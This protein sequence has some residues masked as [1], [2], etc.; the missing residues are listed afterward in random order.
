MEALNNSKPLVLL[1]HGFLSSERAWDPLLKLLREDDQIMREFDFACFNYTTEMVDLQPHHRIPRVKECA[2]ALREFMDAPGCYNR[3]IHLVGHSQ[4]GLIIQG[5]L[6]LMLEAGQGEALRPLRQVMMMA[7]PNLGSE[8][9]SPLR[10][11]V[12]AVFSNPQERALRVLDPDMADIRSVI[13]ERVLGAKTGGSNAWPVPIHIFYGSQDRIVVE[14]SARGQFADANV[15]PLEADHFTIITP[16]DRQDQRYTK[17][18]DALLDPSG[19]PSV[20]EI[21]LYETRVTV[22]PSDKPE[23]ECKHGQTTKMVATDNIGFIERAVTFSHRNRCSDSFCI[24]YSTR[25][26]GYVSSVTSHRNEATP[27]EKGLYDDGGIQTVFRFMPKAGEQYRIKTDVYGG[28]GQGERDV[29]FH[30]SSSG[31]SYSKRRPYILDLSG[32]LSKV[33]KITQ[34]PRLYFHDNDPADHDMC[35][36]RGL[37]DLVKP[38]RVDDSGV[39]TWEFTR[40]SRG[41]VDITWDF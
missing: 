20:Y 9:L 18:S 35:S 11:I 37:G 36:V 17:F 8:F 38:L 1:V 2:K 32:Y 34:G 23:Y 26:G 7:T 33:Y 12:T 24:R 41:V 21:D 39:W 13:T 5:Y 10:K 22:Q 3:E 28:F 27:E 29:H 14:A 15:T 4:G 30:M 16:K 31:N 40:I 19:H 25:H 6:A